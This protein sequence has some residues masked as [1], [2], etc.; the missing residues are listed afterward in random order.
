MMIIDYVK[1]HILKDKQVTEPQELQKPQKIQKIQKPQ[2]S[3]REILETEAIDVSLDKGVIPLETVQTPIE[4]E[5]QHSFPEI[6]IENI[7]DEEEGNDF[8]LG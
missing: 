8:Q 2:V 3:K 6:D 7:I 5:N 1:E 4:T